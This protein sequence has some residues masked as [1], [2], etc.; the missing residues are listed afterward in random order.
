M[1]EEEEV[2]GGLSPRVHV[3]CTLNRLMA[4]F[5]PPTR[6]PY[7]QLHQSLI[8]GSAVAYLTGQGRSSPVTPH[9]C[10]LRPNEDG[11]LLNPSSWETANHHQ[12]CVNLEF[13]DNQSRLPC[14]ITLTRNETVVVVK[15]V[16]EVRTDA[17]VW[18]STLDMRFDLT[19]RVF[20]KTAMKGSS[21]APFSSRRRQ[22]SFVRQEGSWSKRQSDQWNVDNIRPTPSAF[23]LSFVVVSDAKRVVSRVLLA[24]P[25]QLKAT[26]F[27]PT[28]TFTTFVVESCHA[29]LG[30]NADLMYV[31]IIN[32]GCPNTASGFSGSFLTYALSQRGR[33]H[34]LSAPSINLSRTPPSAASSSSSLISII[35][36]QFPAFIISKEHRYHHQHYNAEGTNRNV[37]FRI[38]SSSFQGNASSVR[39]TFTCGFRLCAV[40]AWCAFERPCSRDPEKNTTFLPPKVHFAVRSLTLEVANPTPRDLDTLNS[41]GTQGCSSVF[42]Q[43]RIQLLLI[44]ASL[45]AMLCLSMI[46][47]CLV[48]RN[49]HLFRPK[50]ATS[51]LSLPN[52]TFCGPHSAFL[53]ARHSVNSSKPSS[54]G[55]P[56]FMTTCSEDVSISTAFLHH[57]PE[58]NYI[59]FTNPPPLPSISAACLHDPHQSLPR[60]RQ[61]Q[62]HQ[63]VI[64]SAQIDNRS[65]LMY[66]NGNANDANPTFLIPMSSNHHRRNHL[67][68]KTEWI[69][70]G[71]EAVG[72]TP[73][74]ICSTTSPAFAITPTAAVQKNNHVAPVDSSPKPRSRSM[75]TYKLEEFLVY[76]GR[77]PPTTLGELVT[78]GFMLALQA[79]LFGVGEQTAVFDTRDCHRQLDD[80]HVE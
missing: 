8:D 72:H 67:R 75:S 80:T 45:G 25:I 71:G 2:E 13:T 41:H 65:G 43:P 30:S 54:S 23:D 68:G 51:S 58:H 39:V 3:S 47:G 49:H 55:P 1:E 73:T 59:Q 5:L 6:P 9:L 16:L 35:S 79:W 27:D 4:C 7:Q 60:T 61:L 32:R 29:T 37:S 56:Q 62:Y 64:S 28:G 22:P 33:E 53:A 14:G 57:E 31:N 46:C 12:F 63:A 69:W 34:D 44:M 24:S 52:L 77:L 10:I 36:S 11:F 74:S 18:Q 40:R 76:A 50:S 48:S 21:T 66:A 70:E 17:R 20:T 42:C 15:A 26:L 38:N 19:C 78:D